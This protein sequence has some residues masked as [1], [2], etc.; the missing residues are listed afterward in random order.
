[1]MYAGMGLSIASQ[2]I[3]SRQLVTPSAAVVDLIIGLMLFI[4]LIIP[5]RLSVK[6]P[7]PVQTAVPPPAPPKP[8]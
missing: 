4:A 6:L 1:M 8:M 7:A 3:V 2:E 5:W